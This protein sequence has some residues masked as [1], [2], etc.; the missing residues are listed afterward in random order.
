M[1]EA[2]NLTMSARELDRLEI[3]RRVT[4]RRLTQRMAAERL[5]LS[6]RQVERLCRA[7]RTSGAAGLVSRISGRPWR[8]RSSPSSTASTSRV[9]RYGD[10]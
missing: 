6:L 1:K 4:E 2:G 10:G 7:F 5:S 3:I 9:R 8:A